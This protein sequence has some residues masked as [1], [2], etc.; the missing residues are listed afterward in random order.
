VRLTRFVLP[1]VLCL[2]ALA[3]LIDL[4]GSSIWDANEAY[5]VETPREMLE[6]GDWVNPTFNYEPRFNKPVLAY[7]IVG[8]LYKVFGVS[9]GVERMAIAGLAVAMLIA[10]WFLGRAASLHPAAPVLAAI[11]LAVNP[12]F[13]MFARRILIDVMLAA[14]MT[15]ILLC[16]ALAERYPERRRLFLILMYVA[17]GLGVLAK[18]PVAAALP[19]LVF[20]LYL[21]IHREWR[22]LRDMM[23]PTGAA[24]ALAIAAPW[25]LALYAQGGWTHISGFFLGENVDRF[26][27][28]FGPTGRGPFFYLGVMFTDSLPWSLALPA[29]LA[30]WLRDR[31]ERASSPDLRIR[32]LLWLWIAVIVGFFS[33]SQT[34]QDLYIFPIVAVVA[35]LGA[36]VLARLAF[37]DMRPG[38]VSRWLTGTLAV[39]AL[40][41][42]LGGCFALYVISRAGAGFAIDGLTAVALIAL[43][44]AAVIAMLIVR[45]QPAAAV[46]AVAVVFA[47]FNWLLV[48]RVLPSFERYKPSVAFSDVIRQHVQPGDT[49]AHFEAAMPSMVFYLRRH[50]DLVEDQQGFV[51]MMQS[52]R[53]V[54]VVLPERRYQEL[55]AAFGVR[56]CVLDR[57]PAADVKLR[58]VLAGRGPASLVLVTTR[59]Q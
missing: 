12:R 32:T 45:R 30:I 29:A 52:G 54:Y 2:A 39:G 11:G 9:V 43:T 3:Y 25:Y 33:F 37:A 28:T 23:I 4:G 55:G 21:G 10:A 18:G 34:K 57:R 16:F 24:I 8:G 44:A 6:R 38:P 14:F 31:R 13:F 35:V 53:P 59:C 50:I 19:A 49:V 22:R 27:S 58:D 7:W 47:A 15:L 51:K 1:A 26:T 42:G 41:L 48:G 40:L 5:Y 46:A 56:T 17:V 20:L 36:D